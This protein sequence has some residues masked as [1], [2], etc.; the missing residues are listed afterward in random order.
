[1]IS[2]AEI[3]MGEEMP[4]GYLSHLSASIWGLLSV[5]TG[6][7]SRA[8]LAYGL[9]W[10]LHFFVFFGFLNF[11][12]ISKHQHIMTAPFNVFFST[13]EPKGRVQYIKDLE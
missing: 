2:G 8:D 7:N 5:G 10:W 6:P 9:S 13:L 3:R 12:P 11:L 4:G 1:M